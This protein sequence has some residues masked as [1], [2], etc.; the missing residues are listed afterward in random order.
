MLR[1][2]SSSSAFVAL[3]AEDMQQPHEKQDTASLYG[4]SA[5]VG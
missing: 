5:K 1:M 3:R 2:P 4:Q